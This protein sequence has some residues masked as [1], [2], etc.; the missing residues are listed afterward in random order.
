MDLQSRH[1]KLTK[2]VV[3]AMTPPLTLS[4]CPFPACRL[5]VLP[6][7][8]GSPSLQPTVGGAH[9]NEPWKLDQKNVTIRW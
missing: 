7:G 8:R 9:Y 2:L 4:H 3:A 6:P 1:Y 5:V